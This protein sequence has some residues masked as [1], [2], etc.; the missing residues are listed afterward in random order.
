MFVNTPDAIEGNRIEKCDTA[1]ASFQS[2]NNGCVDGIGSEDDII[3]DIHELLSACFR[4]TTREMYIQ[5]HV[6][7]ISTEHVTAWL[8]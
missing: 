7:M 6:R 1:A 4:S 8:I 3:A 2:E 5:T